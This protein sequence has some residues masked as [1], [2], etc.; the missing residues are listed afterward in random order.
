MVGAIRD[1]KNQPAIEAALA[2]YLAGGSFTG[3]YF[4]KL[5]VGTS[6]QDVID[7][8]DVAALWALSVAVGPEQSRALLSG[9][10]AERITAGL[11]TTPDRDLVEL[12]MD[13][14]EDLV[15]ERNDGLGT[16]WRAIRSVNEMGPV[17]T[18]KLLSRKRPKLVPIYDAVVDATLGM[19]GSKSQWHLYNVALRAD[20][21][22]LHRRLVE[23]TPAGSGLSALR[24]FDIIVWMHGKGFLELAKG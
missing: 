17:K 2:K 13:E 22:A 1:P 4:E 21:G 14:V 23:L 19:K 3:A 12:T 5:T 18:S 11:R 20:D 7:A 9:E 8:G 24:V 10:V 6:D 15:D 16:A